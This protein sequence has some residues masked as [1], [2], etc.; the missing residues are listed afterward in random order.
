MHS[1]QP[2]VLETSS[3]DIKIT[4]EKLKRYKSPGIDPSKQ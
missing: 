4:I 2:L 1:A 3:F